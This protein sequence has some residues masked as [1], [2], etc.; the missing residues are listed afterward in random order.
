MSEGESKGAKH[1][2]KTTKNK[3]KFLK[4]E[5]EIKIM[6]IIINYRK[7]AI[8]ISKTFSKKAA[9]YNSQEYNELKAAKA[10]FPTYRVCVK[11]TPKRSMEDKITMKDII[12]YVKSKSGAE[13][14]EMQTLK[15]LRGTSVKE[16]KKASKDG[17]IFKVEETASFMEIKKWFFATYSE[18]AEK[19]DKRQ[20]QIDEIIAEAAQN[21]ASA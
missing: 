2:P 20:A 8:E 11:S 13:S 19:S 1:S 12:Y 16:A 17:Y 14:K 3:N 10:D 9:I 6:S 21:A 5:S 18:L 7:N 15:E 4:K